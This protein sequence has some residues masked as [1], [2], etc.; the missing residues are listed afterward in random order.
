MILIDKP[1][2]L[3]SFGV[4]ARVRGVLTRQQGQKVK[5]GHTGT[6][7]PFASGLMV[8]LTGKECK[9]AELYSK[10][11]KVYRATICLGQVSSTGDPEGDLTF[12]SKRQPSRLEIEEVISRF[13]GE[14]EQTPPR[15]SAIKIA[16]QRAYKRARQGQEFEVPKRKVVIY[17]LTI[18]NYQ[19]PKIEIEAHVSSGTYIR[20]LAEDIGQALAVGGYCCQLRRLQVGKMLVQ[21]A[22]SL[23]DFMNRG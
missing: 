9:E 23:D 17:N 12:V 20:S 10:L 5:V 22:Q 4:V 6:L 19:Y 8:L 14:I 11:D 2:G 13:S 16:G 15:Y 1:T 7:D 18:Q 3:T 21:E